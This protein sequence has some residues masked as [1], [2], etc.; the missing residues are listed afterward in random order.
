MADDVL[1]RGID[2]VDEIEKLSSVGMSGEPV[3]GDHLATDLHDLRFAVDEHGHLS[4]AL[5]ESTSQG[6][7]G[8]IP[9]ETKRVSLFMR[10]VLEVIHDRS[11]I[12]HA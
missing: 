6:A 5:L 3:D 4:E 1:G 8:L 10:P 7:F 12:E 9:D 2:A 11:T